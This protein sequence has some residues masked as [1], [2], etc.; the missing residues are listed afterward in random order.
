MNMHFMSTL[1]RTLSTPLSTVQYRTVYFIE[2]T[3]YLWNWECSSSGRIKVPSL[4]SQVTVLLSSGGTDSIILSSPRR[5]SPYP[6][7]TLLSASRRSRPNPT[8]RRRPRTKFKGN[9]VPN[10]SPRTRQ[11][12]RP[13][14]NPSRVTKLSR[15]PRTRFSPSP[16]QN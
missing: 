7:S 14:P 8:T 1:S 10:L 11:S 4:H 16:R 5:Q 12:P 6:K 13:N 2:N 9:T 3:S 15:I